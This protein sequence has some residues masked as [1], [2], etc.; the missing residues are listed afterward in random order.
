MKG[1]VADYFAR[2]LATYD[3]DPP[4]NDYQ[5]G[6]C[7]ALKVASAELATILHT[8]EVNAFAAGVEVEAAHQRERWGDAHDEGKTPFD[9][10]WLVGYLSQKAATAAVAGD[11]E[12]AKHHTISTAAAL[13]NWH[14]A[15][16]GVDTSMRPGIDPPPLDLTSAMMVSADATRPDFNTTIDF[17]TIGSACGA[18]IY[19][20]SV[21][22][23]TNSAVI[24]ASTSEP[25]WRF[26]VERTAVDPA[27]Q[28]R[29]CEVWESYLLWC[30][31][32]GERN[33]SPRAFSAALVNKG[34]LKI[35]SDEMRWSGL[36]LLEEPLS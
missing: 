17:G 9:W 8:P 19:A 4:T 10:F 16:A 29:S 22:G 15:L 18:A 34:Y 13:A 27:S 6:H 30:E 5:R 26:L 36:R 3:N 7:E 33:L 1:P 28:V 12:K 23:V 2:S 35:R 21:G 25:L 24:D 32:E 11:I 14:L 20:T 31:R